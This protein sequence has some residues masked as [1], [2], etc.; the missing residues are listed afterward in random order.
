MS[1]YLLMLKNIY[2]FFNLDNINNNH[3]YLALS[4]FGKY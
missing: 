2:C 3:S 1:F 4:A